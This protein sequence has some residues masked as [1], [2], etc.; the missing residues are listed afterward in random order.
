M[1]NII[2]NY[3]PQV[4]QEDY[5]QREIVNALTLNSSN[6]FLYLNDILDDYYNLFIN[7]ES[8][9][10]EWLDINAYYSGFG[11]LWD[12]SWDTNI[13]RVL[14][15]NSDF[16]LQNRGNYNVLEFLFNTFNLNAKLIPDDGVIL[17]VSILPDS[18][19]SEPFSY[20]LHIPNSYG[21]STPEYKLVQTILKNFVACYIRIET[22]Y[23]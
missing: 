12:A 21:S 8:C 19:S 22:Q 15:K 6:Y 7:P 1:A 14:L 20:T 18:F 11:K 9:L 5:D 16:I 13:K 17:D 3:L 23:F 10:E 4:Y 2:L